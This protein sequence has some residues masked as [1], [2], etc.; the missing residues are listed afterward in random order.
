MG[1]SGA[2]AQRTVTIADGTN[3][4]YDTYGT[5]SSNVFTTNSAAGMVGLTFSAPTINKFSSIPTWNNVSALVIKPSANKTAELVTLTAPS[6]FVITGYSFKARDYSASQPYYIDTNANYNTDKQ[7]VGT[8]AFKEFNVS[9]NRTSS[10]SFWIYCDATSLNWLCFS[11][12]TVTIDAADNT[13]QL[14]AGKYRM[15]ETWGAN[16][17]YIYAN[18]TADTSSDENAT[19]R[20]WKTNSA[21]STTLITNPNYI[22]DVTRSGYGNQI[23]NI[24]TSQYISRFTSASSAGNSVTYLN[25]TTANDA[26]FFA[27]DDRNSIVSGAVALK[28]ATYPTSWLNVYGSSDNQPSY[29]YVGCHSAS[30]DG[31]R[32]TFIPVK[33]V[34]YSPAV[35]VNGTAVSTIYVATDGSESITLPAGYT[36][37]FGGADYSNTDAAAE[38]AAAGN[39]DITVTVTPA[40]VDQN[41]SAGTFNHGGNEGGY[42]Q[43]T[44]NGIPTITI[45]S[46]NT[47]NTSMLAAIKNGNSSGFSLFSNST[48]TFNITAPSG[49]VINSYTIVGTATGGDVTFM[50]TGGSATV[51]PKDI[52]ATACAT[53][54]NSSTASFQL[55]GGQGIYLD[56]VAVYVEYTATTTGAVLN[57]V[58]EGTFSHGGNE[59]GYAQWT[60]NGTP[61]ITIIS[62]NTANESMLAAIKNGNS[63]G[64]SLFSNTTPTFNI[65][66]PDGYI[67][68]NYTIVGTAK[69]GNVTFSPTGG[70]S[71]T[72]TQDVNTVAF[73]TGLNSSTT[74]FQLSGGQGIYLDNV[75]IYV[76]YEAP[77][78]VT[79]Q[80]KWSDGTSLSSEVVEGIH[81]GNAVADHVP[82]AFNNDFVTLSYS[83]ETIA[84]ETTA[85]TVT[86]TWNGPFQLSDSYASAKW[87]TVGIRTDYESANHIWKYNSSNEMIGTDAVAT[88]AYGSITDNHLFCFVG[89]PYEGFSIYNKAAGSSK[90]LYKSSDYTAQA[91]MAATGSLFMP[92][93]S[94]V[95]EKTIDNG[96]ACF[97]TKGLVYYLNCDAGN[98]YGIYGWNFINA[99]NTCWFIEPSEYPYNYLAALPLEAPNK[100]VGTKDVNAATWTAARSHKTTLAGDPFYYADAANRTTINSTL[101]ALDAASTITL[102]NGYWRI[103]NA[104]PRFE[105]NM[106]IIYNSGAGK[107]TWAREKTS[108]AIVDNVFKLT[109]NDGMYDIFSCNAQ[110]YLVANDGTLAETATSSATMTALSTTQYNIN[111]A[112]SGNPMHPSG[113]NT[114]TDNVGTSGNLTSYQGGIDSPSAWYIVKVEEVDV[115]LNSI[116]SDYYATLYLPFAYTLSDGTTAYTVAVNNDKESVTMTSVEGT[117]PAGTPVVLKGSSSSAVATIAADVDPLSATNQLTGTYETI[118]VASGGNGNYFLAR[119]NGEAAFLK[120][121]GTDAATLGANRAYLDGSLLSTQTPSNVFTLVFDDDD[122]TAIADVLNGQSSMVNEYRDLQGRKVAQPQRGQIYIVNGKKVLY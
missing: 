19:K 108:A 54:L 107:I 106:A 20:L 114:T 51:F 46:N 59:G 33:T 75:V 34:T 35:A 85:V 41:I 12:F 66:V 95:E 18:P 31:D 71:T 47:D 42:A 30:H 40:G 78:S 7:S 105:Q 111:L 84:S 14:T 49:Y 45:I 97:L 58:S 110:K 44:S 22:W 50:P 92:T 61:A 103:V 98:E 53:G 17:F 65:S 56:N 64:L 21:S 113:H 93:A 70:T 67:I 55:S 23:K 100:A 36:Y 1:M 57:D 80:L 72:F 5:V 29:N 68:K 11:E 83:P 3:P 86:A 8:N 76:E 101:D 28:S 121:V 119:N 90:T 15:K 4:P 60:S 16:N 2:W 48:P 77:M 116:G 13:K 115:A 37:T 118:S 26:E 91:Y 6:G 9:V 122:V 24:G 109:A 27:I 73:V 82:A 117:I 74:S 69:S 10:A 120:Y 52:N 99:G 89:N 79:Y 32:F 102:G 38:I 81:S 112:A 104:Q 94:T 62:N 87:Y 25:A 96:Y 63:Y 39:S 88:N 43:W